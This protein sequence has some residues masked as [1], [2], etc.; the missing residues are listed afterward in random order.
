[1]CNYPRETTFDSS[2]RK[3]REKSVLKKYI[4]FSNE[5][6]HVGQTDILHRV[7]EFRSVLPEENPDELSEVLDANIWNVTNCVVNVN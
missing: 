5:S 6:F 1:M 3:I 2:Y 7:T 4:K